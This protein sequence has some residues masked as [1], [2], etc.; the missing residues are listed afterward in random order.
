M[1]NARLRDPELPLPDYRRYANAI[2]KELADCDPVNVMCAA[3]N[4]PCPKPSTGLPEPK[5]C[6]FRE[7]VRGGVPPTYVHEMFAMGRAFE[8]KHDVTRSNAANPRFIRSVSRC[9]LIAE[10]WRFLGAA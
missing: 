3:L 9:N 1:S 10:F 6:G 2:V 8:E 4:K 7:S 5:C